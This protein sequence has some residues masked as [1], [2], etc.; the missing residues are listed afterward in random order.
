MAGHAIDYTKSSRSV[1]NGPPPCAGSP[2][3]VG[4]IRYGQRIP[5]R[6]GETVVWRHWGCVTPDILR[7]LAI[8]DLTTIAGFSA[9]RLEDQT[10][11]R[12]AIATGRIDPF[13]I[14]VSVKG[15]APPMAQ[16]ASSTTPSAQGSAD[17]SQ[18]KRKQAPESSSSLAR[19]GQIA[20]SAETRHLIKD[21]DEDITPNESEVIDELYCTYKTNVVG[22]RYYKGLVGAGEQVGLVREPTNQYD[23]NAIKVINIGGVQVGHIPRDVAAKLASLID[24]KQVTLEGTMLGGNLHGFHYSLPLEMRIYGASDKCDILESQLMWATPGQR[25]FSL[26]NRNIPTVPSPIAGPSYTGSLYAY[27]QPTSSQRGAS[28]SMQEE[29]IK[30]QQDALHNAAV[31]KQMLINL[32]KV[33]DE[34]RRASLLDTL[35]SHD[36]ILNL[37][38]HPSPP[39]IASRELMVDLLK[40]QSQALQWCIEHEHPVLPTKESDKPVQFWQ[41]CKAGDKPYYFNLATKTPQ[42]IT[43]PPVLGRGALVAD[44]MG[45]G[46]TLTMLALILATKEDIPTN[47]SKSTLIVVPLSVMSN[48]EKQIEEHCVRDAITTC[49]YYGAS[50]NVTAGEIARYDVVITTYQTVVG[51]AD[52]NVLTDGYM[53]ERPNKKKKKETGLFGVKWKRVILDEGHSIRNPKTKMTKAVCNLTAHRRWVLSGTPIIN[54][55]RDMG[56]I[57]TFLQICHPLDSDDYFKRLVLRPLKDGNPAGAELLRA[58]MSHV[59]IRRTKEMQDNDGNPLVPLPPVDITLVRVTLHEEARALYD[60]VEAVSHQRVENMMNQAGGVGAIMASN[61]LSMLTRLRQIALHPDLI[62]SGYLEQLQVNEQLGL[63]TRSAITITPELKERLQA[64]LA[65]SVED[66]EECPICF[67]TLIDPRITS[68]AHG[69]CLACISEVIKRDQRCPMDRYPIGIGDLVELP[70]PTELTQVLVKLDNGNDSQRRSSAKIDQLIHMLKLLPSNEKSLVFSQFTSFLDKIGEMLEMHGIPHVRFDGQLSAKKRQEV[71]ERFTIP[72][73]ESSD[74]LSVDIPTQHNDPFDDN[75]F[76]ENIS[77]SAKRVKAKNKAK[78]GAYDDSAF[79]GVIPRVMLISLKAGALGL[80]LTVANNVFLMD[81]W[82]QEGIESQAIDRCNR[83]GQKRPVH[84]Y[85]L[86]AEDTVETRVIEIQD[87]KK[88]LIQH[89]FS[90]IKGTE[91][92]RERREARLQDLGELFGICQSGLNRQNEM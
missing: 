56:S 32:E 64:Q 9:L 74:L 19:P 75:D 2:I 30:K 92:Q 86:I 90:G 37:P 7:N 66:N 47:H 5:S 27:S 52:P 84:V 4:S 34:G 60:A 20:M 40:H 28:S 15:P 1:C 54:S 58:L 63:Q 43:N 22:V 87:R 83:I 17:P 14:P 6:F 48:W 61:M 44:S 29:A 85:Q 33:D 70:P 65:K 59:C 89:A 8:E 82:W 21:D 31:L 13:D 76:D 24:K 39:G 50:R 71:L 3:A 10:K 35:C 77:F 81:P 11:V 67:G 26:E 23:R 68:C 57:L 53:A 36:D 42:E 51:E 25:G 12:R 88:R 62:P 72:L 45:L 80:N 41:Y 55:P 16:S 18:R 73:E 49:V 79:Y 78:A 46:K 38:V 91:T 69:F